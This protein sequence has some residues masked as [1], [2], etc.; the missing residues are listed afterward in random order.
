MP[1][2][3]SVIKTLENYTCPFPCLHNHATVENL[4]SLSYS[5]HTD[6]VQERYIHMS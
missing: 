6:Q 5:V 1:K 4:F 2:E 3:K